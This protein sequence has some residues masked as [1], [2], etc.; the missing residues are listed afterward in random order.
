ML[1]PFQANTAKI[2]QYGLFVIVYSLLQAYVFSWLLPFPF[3]LVLFDSFV[4]A[5]LF[6]IIAAL[7]WKVFRYGN[8]AVLTVFQQTL[9]NIA[10]A[11]I[12][13]TVW[14][15]LGFGVLYW[16]FEAE[17]ITQLIPLLPVRGFIG[18]LIYGI[19]IQWFHFQLIEMVNQNV[20]IDK[21]VLAEEIKTDSNTQT[22][23]L[24]RIAVKSGTKIHVVIIS[25]IL[26]LQADGDYVQ[27]FTLQGK[28]LKEQT[29]KYFEEHLPNNQFVRVH[30][31][32]IV[33]IEMISRIELYEKQN[34]LLTLKNGQQIKTSP[35]GYKALRLALKL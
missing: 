1:L 14:L 35:A 9:N 16:L 23:L 13:L 17:I 33:N 11:L 8:F 4:H 29:M 18:L 30:R 20:E 32:C 24:E 7:L 10:L 26:F 5:V 3:W 28:F 25:E 21:A 27:I 31:S 19:L 6:G 2:I 22:E 12:S 34:Q 15:T